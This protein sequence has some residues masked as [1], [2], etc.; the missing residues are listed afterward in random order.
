MILTSHRLKKNLYKAKFVLQVLQLHPSVK[1]R[2]HWLIS[3]SKFAIGVSVCVESC[4][5]LCQPC[6]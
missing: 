2:G 6:D 1:K 5:S 4:L 3:D